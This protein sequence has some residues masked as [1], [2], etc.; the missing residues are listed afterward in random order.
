MGSQGKQHLA[1]RI[2]RHY[3]LN[4]PETRSSYVICRAPCQMKMWSPLLESC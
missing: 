3:Q 1:L 2:F 4:V